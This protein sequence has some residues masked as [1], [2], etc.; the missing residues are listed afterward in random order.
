MKKLTLYL[1]SLFALACGRQETLQLAEDGYPYYEQAAH[2][3]A[4]GKADSAFVAFNQA[5]EIFLQNNDSLN[6]ANSFIRMGILLTN[7]GD[8]YGGQETSLN[9]LHYLN[10]A[11]PTHRVYLSTNYNNLGRATF[12]LRDY[13]QAL[14]FYDSA[15]AFSDDSL[16]ANVYLNNKARVYQELKDYPR[17]IAIYSQL[18]EEAPIDRDDHARALTNLAVAQS[19]HNPAYDAGPALI[20]ALHFWEEKADVQGMNASFAHLADYYATRN[21]DSAVFYARKRYQSAQQLRFVDEEVHALG[22]L[23]RL[24]P[25]EAAKPY[26]Q[27]YEQLSD[28]LQHRR[29][30][31]KNQFALIRYEVEKSKSENLQL[32]KENA[33][34]ALQVTRN[35]IWTGSALAFAILVVALGLFW[36]RKRAQR[37]ALEAQ[38]QIH[39]H[40][41]RTSKKIH[42]VVANGL[43]RVMAE[44]EN[45]A[46]VDREDILD[47]L[48]RMYEQSRDISYD[49]DE[50]D[51]HVEP[52]YPDQVSSL[53]RSFATQ[54]IAVI[55]AGNEAP[56]WAGVGSAI[57]REA[58]HILQELMVNMRKHSG[59]SRVVVRFERQEGSLHIHYQDNGC[60][61]PETFRRGNGLLNTEN[62]IASLNGNLIFAP[63]GGKGLGITISFPVS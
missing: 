49:H 56:T 1:L 18:L 42:D 59:A 27:V 28:S 63:Q 4:A 47:H 10:P 41:L 35:R 48:E 44:I 3:L 37:I 17:A 33:E 26:F 11:N 43:Y 51:E 45:R 23:I 52:S 58:K 31:A 50:D 14:S 25:P 5:K 6:V 40:R 21:P 61:L 20:E 15:L 8:Y 39:A 12:R 55:I 38:A 46:D 24:S 60:G 62:R 54:S 22:Q 32:Q 36:Y 29:S 2:F 53:L 13:Q 16:S 57:Q 7:Q 34:K 19:Q 30:T 9:A